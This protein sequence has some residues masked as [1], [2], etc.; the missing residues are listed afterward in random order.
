MN[1]TRNKQ[2]DKHDREKQPMTIKHDNINMTNTKDNKE[3]TIG[4]KHAN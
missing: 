4:N 2:N 3:I 1:K